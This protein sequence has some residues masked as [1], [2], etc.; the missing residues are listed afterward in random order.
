[1]A[2]TMTLI[3]VVR[4]NTSVGVGQMTEMI[5][6]VLAKYGSG[7]SVKFDKLNGGQNIFHVRVPAPRVP[8]FNGLMEAIGP[9]DNNFLQC[10]MFVIY[11]W[12]T[13]APSATPTKKPLD[14]SRIGYG[15][16]SSTW[17]STPIDPSIL[18]LRLPKKK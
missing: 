15:N 11:K 4:A 17:T 12:I 6:S 7:A 18:V 9:A 3:A 2:S 13:R 8:Y 16:V 1:M 10:D 14:I 5:K